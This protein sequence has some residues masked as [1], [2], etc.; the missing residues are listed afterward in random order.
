MEFLILYFGVPITIKKKMGFPCGSSGKELACSSG[1]LGSIPRLGR[2][3]G[4]GKGYPLENSMAAHEVAKSW[5]RLNDFHFTPIKSAFILHVQLQ[6]GSRLRRP[7]AWARAV[8][9]ML[10]GLCQRLDGARGGQ[11][12]RACSSWSCLHPECPWCD[13]K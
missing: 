5:T 1:D 12:G 10:T 3:P 4:E 11:A 7:V 8:I 6:A 2:S 13:C 9:W